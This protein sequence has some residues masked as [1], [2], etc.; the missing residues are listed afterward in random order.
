MSGHT[1]T[2]QPLARAVILSSIITAFFFV[3]LGTALAANV[4]SDNFESQSFNKWT[5]VDSGNAGMWKID[6]S[7][8]T[9]KYSAYVSG[10]TGA[11]DDVLRKSFST[12]TYSNPSL[13]LFYKASSLDYKS[14]GSEFDQF[15]VEYTVDGINWI[16]VKEVNGKSTTDLDGS[17]RKVDVPVP[18]NSNFQFRF[19]AH[20]SDSGDRV[21]IDDVMLSG[22]PIENTLDR[23]KDKV[24][25]DSDG[26]TDALDPECDEF[27]SD[28]IVTKAGNGVGLVTSTPAGISCG[29]D[30]IE[31]YLT[32]TVVSLTQSVTRGFEFLGWSGGVCSGFADCIL[33]M[34]TDTPVTATFGA[35]PSHI[36]TT[37]NDASE[38]GSITST[39]VGISCGA[40][41]EEVLYEGETITLSAL[42]STG[43]RFANWSGDCEGALSSV[44]DLTVATAD[45]FATAH[46]TAIPKYLLS[47][48]NSPSGGGTVTSAPTG[49]KC[50]ADCSESYYEDTAVSLTATPAFGF[51]FAGWEGSC[52]GTSA[53]CNLT[54]TAD[55][56]ATA[57]YTPRPA[58]M[59]GD[60]VID[61][62]ESCDQGDGNVANG[63]GCSATCQIEPGFTCVGAPS[64]CFIE[65]V[66]SGY[67][68]VLPFF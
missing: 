62:N 38:T 44:C 25:N 40:D 2:W 12:H 28:L 13:S 14:N 39:P 7:R 30:C 10:A 48:S 1:Q 58:G 35:I 17:W 55:A 8:Y 33:S 3:Y 61:W 32:N 46:Y 21:W 57:L 19:R 63:D 54:L 66:C 29:L 67:V 22:T 16:L 53:T 49:I 64:Q 31:R 45:L 60:A 65:F 5:Q 27:Y 20:L 52:S 23:C 68:C 59:C 37:E 50:G 41:C 43:Y 4:F 9:G 34:Y 47:V 36:L 56:S 6:T 42:P 18:S 11:T 51:E 26:Y 24:D 15:F